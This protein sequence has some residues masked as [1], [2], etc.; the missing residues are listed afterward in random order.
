MFA[1]DLMVN[2][3]LNAL[4]PNTE[5]KILPVMTIGNLVESISHLG[6]FDK[7]KELKEY[8]FQCFGGK[9]V[10]IIPD[11][12]SSNTSI[13]IL[14]DYTVNYV[15]NDMQV[16]Q[17]IT[18]EHYRLALATFEEWTIHNKFTCDINSDTHIKNICQLNKRY[19]MVCF[20]DYTM[21]RYRKTVPVVLV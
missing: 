16:A 11:L 2:A 15:S 17:H 5:N 10:N 13:V 14:D 8:N 7:I 9:I 21:R 3:L 19:Y 18:L 12:S 20:N 6:S 4:Q 1:K